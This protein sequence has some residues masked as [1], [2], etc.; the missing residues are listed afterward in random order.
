MRWHCF[1]HD[2][3]GELRPEGEILPSGGRDL[4]QGMMASTAPWRQGLF[5][6]RVNRT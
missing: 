5:V 4:T 1:R 6:S 2:E 3:S